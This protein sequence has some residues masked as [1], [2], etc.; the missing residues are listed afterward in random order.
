VQSMCYGSVRQEDDIY[1]IDELMP[2]A[3]LFTVGAR[4]LKG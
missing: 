2:D 4:R 1:L 3:Q